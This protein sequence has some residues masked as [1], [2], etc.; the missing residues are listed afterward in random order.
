MKNIRLPVPLA[1]QSDRCACAAACLSAIYF[2][3]R[4]GSKK[5]YFEKDFSDLLNREPN[6]GVLADDLLRAAKK[7][8]FKAFYMKDLG[9]NDLEDFFSCG[10][11][12]LAFIQGGRPRSN[13][14]SVWKRGHVVVPV[15]QN[16]K[17]VYLMDPAFKTSYVR[18][19]VNTFLDCWHAYDNGTAEK[20]THSA[21]IIADLNGGP[22]FTN[23]PANIIDYY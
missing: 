13:Y 7:L 6:R 2:Y 11:T 4:G 10:I 12:A 14:K 21:I 22:V 1:P 19:P 16:K 23:P 20:H 15:G 8:K 18:M 17:Y 5:Y 9:T 3:W